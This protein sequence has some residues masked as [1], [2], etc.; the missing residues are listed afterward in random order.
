MKQTITRGRAIQREHGHRIQSMSRFLLLASALCLPVAAF[1]CNRSRADGAPS[2]GSAAPT[3]STAAFGGG[4][5]PLLP[6]ATCAFPDRIDADVTIEPGCVVDVRHSTLV[7]SGHTLTIG[8]GATLRFAEATYLEVGHKGSRLVARGTADKPILFTSGTEMPKPGDWVGIVFDDAIGK[9][10]ALLEHAIV[11]YA[12]RDSHGGEGAITVFRAFPAGSVSIVDTTFRRDNL[13]AVSNHHDA[14]TFGRFER[15]TFSDNARDLRVSAPVLAAMGSGN[16][17]SDEI[18]VAGGTV[19]KSGELPKTKG[20]IYVTEPIYVGTESS[21][22]K[23]PV[24]LSE[25]P[26]LTIPSGSTLRFAPKTWL[27]VGTKGPGGLHAENVTF[28]SAADKPAPGDWVGL[29]FGEHAQATRVTGSTIQYAGAEE[30]GGDAAITFVGSRSWEGLDVTLL[31][32]TFQSCAQAQLSSNGEGCNKGLDPRNGMV[33]G[34]GVEP[35]R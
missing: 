31:F 33:F 17:L 15:N 30:H 20:A 24:D 26:V 16:D 19:T 29:I 32:I 34:G 10:G 13:A 1:G 11:E 27:E 5:Q 4:P 35:C 9:E 8:A 18:E 25:V 6:G 3:G 22:P 14:A 21:T 2:A 12:G 28:T 23:Y 7:E